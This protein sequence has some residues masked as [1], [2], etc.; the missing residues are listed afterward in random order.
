[1]FS[2][3]PFFETVQTQNTT[4]IKREQKPPLNPSWEVVFSFFDDIH[5]SLLQWCTFSMVS[6]RQRSDTGEMSVRH[7][8]SDSYFL[9]PNPA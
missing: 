6:S 8:C 7:H 1:M 4:V 5:E 2:D 9:G 3:Y